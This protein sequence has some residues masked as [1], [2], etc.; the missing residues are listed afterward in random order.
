MNCIHCHEEITDESR[1]ILVTIDGDFSCSPEC[2][3]K[4]ETERD[5]FFNEVIH[6]DKLMEQW[7]R[8]EPKI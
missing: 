4:Y 8:G 7:W 6:D 2:K 5:R 1:M 3:T